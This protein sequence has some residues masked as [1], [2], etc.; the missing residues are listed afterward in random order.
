MTTRPSYPASRAPSAAFAPASPPPTTT[1]RL[2][3]SWCPMGGER[4]RCQ[5]ADQLLAEQVGVARPARGQVPAVT[6]REGSRVVGGRTPL[7]EDL[8]PRT[9]TAP[10]PRT[11]SS[12]Y[13]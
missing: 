4:S 8:G 7:R 5:H 11:S 10:E 6:H 2:M 12:T 13:A 9:K 1:S 3:I